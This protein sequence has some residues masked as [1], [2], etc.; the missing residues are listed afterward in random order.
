MGKLNESLFLL[1]EQLKQEK[2]DRN[3]KIKELENNTNHE[4][5]SQRKY[6]E[7]SS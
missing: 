4:L 6:N 5:A 3:L 2:D 7:C 1:K